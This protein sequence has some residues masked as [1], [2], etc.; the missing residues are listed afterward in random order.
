MRG[1]RREDSSETHAGDKSSDPL[2][3]QS[4][5]LETTEKARDLKGPL[6]PSAC[7]HSLL[8]CCTLECEKIVLKFS[9][10]MLVG[11]WQ[12]KSEKKLKS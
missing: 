6:H 10:D 3:F 5:D 2:D 7:S 4:S 11:T 8:P 12:R 1:T 9:K